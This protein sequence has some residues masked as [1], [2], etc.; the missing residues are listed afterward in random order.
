MECYNTRVG[1]SIESWFVI[2]LYPEVLDPLDGKVQQEY[3][4]QSTSLVACT[5]EEWSGYVEQFFSFC[6]RWF[7]G[8]GLVSYHMAVYLPNKVEK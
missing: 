4:Y 8:F 5:C 3:P 1:G 6:V 7:F 2:T